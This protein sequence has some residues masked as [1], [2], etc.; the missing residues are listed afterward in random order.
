MAFPALARATLQSRAEPFIKPAGSVSEFWHE[1]S[2]DKPVD[3]SMVCSRP[4][5]GL[6]PVAARSPQH[7]GNNMTTHTKSRPKS[8][9][10][11]LIAQLQR[12][13]GTSID[14]LAKV[15]GW[16]VHSVRGAMA[17]ALRKKG[18]A[19]HSEKVDGVRRYRLVEPADA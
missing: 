9:T 10:D 19:V 18:H 2:V 1:V 8:K 17:G 7:G 3:V 4:N 15:T 13:A 5:S 12:P 11:L 14:D 6:I 16:Q